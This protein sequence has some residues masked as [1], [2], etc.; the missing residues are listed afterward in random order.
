MD[1]Y[2]VNTTPQANGDHEV[3]LEGCDRLKYARFTNYLGI[4]ST[5]CKAIAKASRY[6]HPV[7]GCFYC[8]EECHT[9]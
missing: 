1:R 6:C 9:R 2:Y 3:H 4:L 7:D 8:L 5:S